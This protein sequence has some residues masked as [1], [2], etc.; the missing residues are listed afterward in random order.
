MSEMKDQHRAVPLGSAEQILPKLVPRVWGGTRLPTLFGADA[1][2][3]I[4]EAW[5]RGADHGSSAPLVKLLDVRDR[6]SVQVHPDDTLAHELHGAGEI[7]K[8]EAWVIIEA[9]PGATILLGRDPNATPAQL[10]AALEAS[11]SIESLLARVPVAAGDVIDV[12]PGLLHALLPRLLVW[13]LQQASDRTYRVSDWDRV[14]A[15]R[16]LHRSEAL[17]ATNANAMAGRNAQIPVAV[18]HHV[19]LDSGALRIVAIVGP[20]SGRVSTSCGD[21]ATLVPSPTK[22]PSS[23]AGTPGPVLRAEIGGC[24][25]PL[26]GSARLGGGPTEVV[27]PKRGVLLIG[28]LSGGSR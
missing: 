10:T 11:A 1:P 27:L 16:P 28:A 24:A 19:L 7:G 5:F 18:G 23:S 14:D 22:S 9:D 13:E 20:W 12:P 6:L 8:H 17:R 2:E 26:F 21:V 15:R 25:L 3:M 4:G